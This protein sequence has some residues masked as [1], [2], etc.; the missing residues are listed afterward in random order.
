MCIA[1]FVFLEQLPAGPQNSHPFTLP[2]SLAG[3]THSG[4]FELDLYVSVLSSVYV[5]VLPF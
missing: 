2:I 3:Q 5:P 4:R 1:S